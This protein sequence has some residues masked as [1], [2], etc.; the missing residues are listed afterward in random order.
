MTDRRDF[1]PLDLDDGEAY[2]AR[3]L[4]ALATEAATACLGLTVTRLPAVLRPYL[5]RAVED[6]YRAWRGTALALRD[7]RDEARV[8]ARAWE[9]WA[10]GCADIMQRAVAQVEGLRDERE[11]ARARADQAEADLAH[12]LRVPRPVLRWLRVRARLLVEARD[13]AREA[14]RDW[15]RHALGVEARLR[16]VE[17]AARDYRAATTARLVHQEGYTADD[18]DS[19]PEGEAVSDAYHLTRE[20]LDAVLTKEAG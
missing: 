4:D 12:L 1:G 19:G 2:Q 20:R 7:E 8:A 9:E 5:T 14:A 3:E 17:R 13:H 16:E 15:R 11:K 10:E 18:W 6:T